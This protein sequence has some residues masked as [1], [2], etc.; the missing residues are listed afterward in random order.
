MGSL[1]SANRYAWTWEAGGG[2]TDYIS[3]HSFL[4]G[5]LACQKKVFSVFWGAFVKPRKATI[6]YDMSVSL[7]VHLSVRMKQLGFYWTDFHEIWYFSIFRKSAKKIQVS[8]K[9][10]KNNGHFTLRP[11]YI[12]DGISHSSS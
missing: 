9:P 1:D 4:P 7:S 2:N 3:S 8:L 6:T 11:S 5:M 12:Y 10:D